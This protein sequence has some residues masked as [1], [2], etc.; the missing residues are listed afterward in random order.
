MNTTQQHYT[1]VSAK[2]TKPVGELLGWSGDVAETNW[3]AKDDADL[4]LV[5]LYERDKPDGEAE[6]AE[7][8][9][10]GGCGQEVNARLC[11]AA[12]RLYDAARRA[13]AFVEHSSMIGAAELRLAL[14]AAI[15]AAGGRR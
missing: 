12:P 7:V 10:C 8:A 5:E 11:A 3:R 6:T 13:L 14:S 15:V 1:L 4:T 9:S 2:D